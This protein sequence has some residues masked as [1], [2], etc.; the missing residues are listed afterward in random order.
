VTWRDKA[1][2]K[3]D[4]SFH[5]HVVHHMTHQFLGVYYLKVWLVERA[6]WL[7]EGLANYA[8][9]QLFGRAGNSCNTEDSEEDM[10]DE[11]W[12]SPTRKLVM[13]KDDIPFAQL[14]TK[15]ADQMGRNDHL[16]AWSV[17][18][19]MMR[20]APEK[21]PELVRKIT[22]EGF[23]VAVASRY[24]AGGGDARFS[25]Q[26]S[27]VSVHVVLS[28]S[29]MAMATQVLRQDFHDWSSGY[30]AWERSAILSLLPLEGDYGEYFMEMMCRAFAAGFRH[31]EVPYVL[32]PRQHGLSKTAT[33]YPAM[34][35]RGRKYLRSLWRCRALL[36]PDR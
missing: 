8:E 11:H 12:E 3:T 32:T 16:Q 30:V 35:R 28:W 4:E 5:Q 25:A 36:R 26:G 7:E 15:R 6:G 29:L 14:V 20:Q 9:M 13:K 2:F 21:I 18:D 22:D 10:A 24:V 27:L 1:V 31:V 19:W 17:V 23:D 34:I 33:T